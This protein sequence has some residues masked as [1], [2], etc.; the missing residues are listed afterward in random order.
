MC[1]IFSL[2]ISAFL[3]FPKQS[4]R[5]TSVKIASINR[6]AN[7]G[8]R[9]FYRSRLCVKLLWTCVWSSVHRCCFAMSIPVTRNMSQHEYIFCYFQWPFKPTCEFALRQYMQDHVYTHTQTQLFLFNRFI[10]GSGCK[11]NDGLTGRRLCR[12]VHV[13]ERQKTKMA[14]S[15]QLCKGP[16]VRAGP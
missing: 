9:S 8:C 12:S 11:V 5:F 4:S 16:L 10:W 1:E 15:R 6:L 13:L 7:K 3:F 14:K 2:H